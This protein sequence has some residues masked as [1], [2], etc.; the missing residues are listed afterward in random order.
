LKNKEKERKTFFEEFKVWILCCLMK[1]FLCVT[2]SL[3]S[4]LS[5]CCVCEYEYV[6]FIFI[7]I[8]LFFCFLFWRLFT[9][10]V[11]PTREDNISNMGP[12][13]ILHG[14]IYSLFIV[15]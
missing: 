14:I 2:L 3:C 9:V 1:L 6:C 12:T 7:I 11:E 13:R 5:L 8:F 4:V 10:F 15:I